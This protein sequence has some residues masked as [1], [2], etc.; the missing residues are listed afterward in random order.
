MSKE[1]SGVNINVYVNSSSES[2]RLLVHT[3]TT[4]KFDPIPVRPVQTGGMLHAASGLPVTSFIFTTPAPVTNPNSAYVFVR[5]LSSL[6]TED[7]WI[8]PTTKYINEIGVAEYQLDITVDPQTW[9]T[10]T[11]FRV[12]VIYDVSSSTDKEY[13]IGTSIGTLN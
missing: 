13:Y 9:P 3:D 6:T 2:E 4:A 10:G 8:V 1:S 11:T 12:A 7:R 5:K